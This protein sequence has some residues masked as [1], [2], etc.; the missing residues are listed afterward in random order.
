MSLKPILSLSDRLELFG[1]RAGE[2]KGELL[3]L[4]GEKVGRARAWREGLDAADR[5]PWVGWK[6][7]G[8]M[9]GLGRAP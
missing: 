9:S 8:E 1:G 4:W 5:W 6:E 3:R 7:P 2:M